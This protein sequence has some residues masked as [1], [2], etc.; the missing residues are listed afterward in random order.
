MIWRLNTNLKI[1]KDKLHYHG[2]V[3]GNKKKELLLQSNIFIFPTYYPNEAQPICSLEAMATG[4]VIITTKQGGIPDIIKEGKNGFFV[5]QK[6][7]CDIA[8]TLINIWQDKKRLKKI[9]ENNIIEAKEKYREE[10][11][12]KGIERVLLGVL[13]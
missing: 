9:S 3:K 1:L 11:F 13:N 6:N 12:C 2:F 8:D 10:K 5:E 7:P 4:N